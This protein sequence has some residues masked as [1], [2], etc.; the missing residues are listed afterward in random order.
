[1]YTPTAGYSG[2]DSFTYNVNDGTNDSAPA[3]ASL[4]VIAPPP[5]GSTLTFAATH[6]AQVRSSTP[7]TNYGS[8]AT[9]RLGGEGTTTTYRT[10]L[11]FDVSGLTGSVTG[12]KLRLFATDAS[13][14]VVHVLPVADTTWT[15]GAIT[16]D[17]KPATGTP[18]A[19]SAA[20]PTLNGY[21][22]ITLSSSSV[23]GNGTVSFGLTIEGTN[24]AIFSSAEGANAPQL[25]VTHS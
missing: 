25:V 21:N 17:S 10:Y 2:P 15:E 16:W 6:D 7:T 3:T 14:N 23:S 1:M 22:E 8:L 18:D 4:T 11:K 19:G 13:S 24:S 9:V 20:V 12:V 5:P